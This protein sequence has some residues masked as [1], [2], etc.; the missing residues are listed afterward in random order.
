VIDWAGFD[1]GAGQAVTFNQANASFVA[2]NRVAP[3]ALTTID[4]ALNA[5]GGVWLFAP[6]GLLFGANARVNTGAFAAGTGFLRDDQIGA[7]LGGG[8]LTLSSNPAVDSVAVARGAELRAGAGGLVLQGERI[9]QDGG[10]GAAGGVGYLVSD[11]GVLVGD[12]G[13]VEIAASALGPLDGR[14]DH[15]GETR[16]GTYVQITAQGAYGSGRR[17]VIN[18][19]GVLEARGVRAGGTDSL[20]IGGGSSTP[21]RQGPERGGGV[22]AGSRRGAP[23][24]RRATYALEAERATLGA[25]TAGGGLDG[26]TRDGLTLSGPATL[27]GSALLRSDA[28]ELTIA[29]PL[30]AGGDVAGL[31]GADLTVAADMRAGGGVELVAER[32]LSLRTGV[33]I[34]SDRDGD[35]AG[36]LRLTANRDVN[37]TGATLLAG[38]SAATPTADIEVRVGRY[39]QGGTPAQGGDLS[40][41]DLS[42]RSIALTALAAGGRGG[43]VTLAGDVRAGGA[44]LVE[45]AA[46]SA[47][48]RSGGIRVLGDVAADGDV[49]LFNFGGGDLQVGPGASVVGDGDDRDGGFAEFVWLLSSGGI[50]VGPDARVVSGQGLAID[51]AGV[52]T[53]ADGA[54]LSAPG[55]RYGGEAR[56]WPLAAPLGLGGG[57]VRLAAADID[58]R[59]AVVSGSAGARRDIDIEVRSAGPAAVIGGAS[60]PTG[61]FHLSDA[62]V[63]RLTGRA[64]RLQTGLS[65]GRN[66]GVDLTVADLTLDPARLSELWLGAPS[67]RRIAVPG[68]VSSWRVPATSI[69]ALATCGGRLTPWRRSGSRGRSPSPAAWERARRSAGWACSPGETSLWG[70]TLSSAPPA[71]SR[72]STLSG[73]PPASPSRR[74]ASSSARTSCASPHSAASC[75]RTRRAGSASRACSSARRLKTARCC[76]PPSCRA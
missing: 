69:C 64:V 15:A 4:G 9:V 44:L 2:I 75:S 27:G 23:C 50:D 58:L 57:G 41:G 1:I 53:V 59:G 35:G 24:R 33:T 6:G 18:L 8:R 31:G 74:I 16:A 7:A 39:A 66:V 67:D 62:E 45:S 72:R 43:R 21:S 30:T 11:G 65:D 49:F 63:Q 52:L 40:L 48:D 68:R 56:T 3:G 36:E 55:E 29:G 37:T 60:A 12:G 14:L 71:A 46:V 22:A 13:G 42:G 20:L 73:A 32:D 61:A 54:L 70:P 76:S 10:V 47:A 51:A 25:V 28:G 5:T 26:L 38:P 19:D 17:T 34:Q